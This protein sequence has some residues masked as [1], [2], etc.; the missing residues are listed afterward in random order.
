M[1]QFIFEYPHYKRR[2]PI[3]QSTNQQINQ[4]TNQPIKIK[5]QKYGVYT[6]FN[7]H[8]KADWRNY[9]TNK[10]N[11]KN[12]FEKEKRNNFKETP[13]IVVKDTCNPNIS[14]NVRSNSS[15]WN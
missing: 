9:Q 11:K 12:T 4:S 15:R 14:A 2:Q 3:N 13:S 6:Q 1:Q 8:F 7:S 10:T 5:K